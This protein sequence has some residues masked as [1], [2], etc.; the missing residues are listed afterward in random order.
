MRH[1]VLVLDDVKG[2]G[3]RTRTMI[4]LADRNAK[5]TVVYDLA[6]AQAELCTPCDTPYTHLVVDLHF[7]MDDDS[8][9]NN[10]IAFLKWLLKE[11]AKPDETR[12]LLLDHSHL[13]IFAFSWNEDY[14]TRMQGIVDQYGTAA[15]QQIT[16]RAYAGES[17]ET[18][19]SLA[20]FV[21]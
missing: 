20:R 16:V 19:Q 2:E 21:R 7:E 9:D 1:N 5:I 12:A 13:P 17:Q 3:E 15:Q 6:S 14:V 10:G 4:L 18:R 11:Q 8:D